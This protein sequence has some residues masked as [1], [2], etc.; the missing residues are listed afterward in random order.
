MQ[1][2]LKSQPK[3]SVID[4]VSEFEKSGESLYQMLLTLEQMDSDPNVK[5]EEQRKMMENVREKA[6]C[7]KY[8]YTK[9]KSEIGRIDG[10]IKGFQMKKK[11]LENGLA[12]FKKD[13]AW[14]LN[15]LPKDPSGK[16]PFIMGNLYKMRLTQSTS[17]NPLVEADGIL[18]MDYEKYIDV[19]YSWK[20]DAIKRG[21]STDASLQEIA[22]LDTTESITFDERKDV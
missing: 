21:F 16:K 14:I 19:K 17:C 13:S 9:F 2:Q 22:R 1:E 6:D 3:N 8:V 20:K 4:Q 7:Y 11:S 12:G 18:N 10:I 15:Q 5:Q